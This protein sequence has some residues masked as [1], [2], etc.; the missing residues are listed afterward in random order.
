MNSTQSILKLIVSS[1]FLSLCYFLLL[2]KESKS[3]SSF[4]VFG[5]V[6]HQTFAADPHDSHL[7][8]LE[9]PISSSSSS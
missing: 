8:Y 9:A 1:L 4:V 5:C 6:F 7:Y 3:S 2:M